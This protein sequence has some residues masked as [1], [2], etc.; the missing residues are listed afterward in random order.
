[1]INYSIDMKKVRKN[2]GKKR[3]LRDLNIAVS[4]GETVMIFGKNGSG[5]TTLIK[6]LSTMMKMEAG[7]VNIC[8]LSSKT[9]GTA[10][11]RI[12]GVVTH[13]TMLYEHLTAYENLKFHGKMFRLNKIEERIVSAAGKMGVVNILNQKISTMSHGTKKRLT[14]ARSLIHDPPVLLMDEPETG[15]DGSGMELLFKMFADRKER[16][17]TVLANTHDL[18]FGETVAHRTASI[19]KGKIVFNKAPD[20]FVGD[21]VMS[22]SDEGLSHL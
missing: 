4:S 2:F 22:A 10:V 8:G 1:M 19:A 14:I 18:Q 12:M 16:E 5:K 9:R 3:V 20:R 7:E 15:L 13:E 21:R 6:I 11:R 17:Q